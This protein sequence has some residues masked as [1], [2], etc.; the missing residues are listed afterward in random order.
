ESQNAT[1]LKD[2]AFARVDDWM[3]EF[4]FIAKIALEE[5]PQ[6]A[7]SL[8]RLVRSWSNLGSIPPC[9]FLREGGSFPAL[10]SILHGRPFYNRK[11]PSPT[12]TK[13]NTGRNPT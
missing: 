13:E 2:A 10:A 12:N 5:S 11:S 1:K 4:Y 9:G 8:G 3:K 6:L 7:E